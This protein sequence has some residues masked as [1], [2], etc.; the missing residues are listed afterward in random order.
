MSLFALQT[1]R[2]SPWRD[3]F[4]RLR[5]AFA[6]LRGSTLFALSCVVIVGAAVVLGGDA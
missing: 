5:L 2:R 3:D 1:R 6:I 4:D